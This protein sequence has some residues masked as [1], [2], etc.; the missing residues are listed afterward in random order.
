MKLDIIFSEF[1]YLVIACL[2]YTTNRK[3]QK[4]FRKYF[5]PFINLFSKCPVFA[6][7]A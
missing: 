6:F 5:F 1:K 3:T 7:Q 4:T 2:S